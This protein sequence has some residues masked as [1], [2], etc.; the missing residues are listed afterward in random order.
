MSKKGHNA[1]NQW[2]QV[3]VGVG[4]VALF[5]ALSIAI[6]VSFLWRDRSNV[7]H[8]LHDRSDES[9]Q[10][11]VLQ[12]PRIGRLEYQRLFEVVSDRGESL[13]DFA[14][15]V[16]P[17]LR[18]FSDETGFEAC[19]VLATDGVRFGIVVGS[20]RSH[21]ACVNFGSKVPEGMT[22]TGQTI[23]SHGKPGRRR[24]NAAD[25]KLM[26]R[27]EMRLDR[28]GMMSGQSLTAFSD[29]DFAGGPGYLAIPGGV[30]H[31]NGNATVRRIGDTRNETTSRAVA[32][33]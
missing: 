33:F 22:N 32:A 28:G 2:R 1:R 19:G 10:I 13:D 25:L 12:V 14:L 17:R 9:G 7:E 31:Q 24:A 5:V 20:S 11:E 8:V 21:V 26:G 3:L 15:R 4:L 30:I 29:M 16:G 23:H 27:G 18:A 6:N